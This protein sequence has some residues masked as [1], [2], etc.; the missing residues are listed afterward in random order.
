M[1]YFDKIKEGL[2]DKLKGKELTMDSEFKGLG[3][4]SLDLVDLVFQLEEE[5]NTQFEDE[6]LMQIKTVRDLCQLIDKKV[7]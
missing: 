3:I 1:D 2:A 6:E 5:L 4:D 7:K